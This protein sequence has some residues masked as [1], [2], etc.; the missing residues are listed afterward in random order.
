MPLSFGVL[1]A[2][3]GVALSFAV[4]RQCYSVP[5]TGVLLETTPPAL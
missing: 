5:D 3:A 2:F 1:L 4:L